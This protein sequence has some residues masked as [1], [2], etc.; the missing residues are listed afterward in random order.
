V[1]IV[2]TTILA[3]GWTAAAVAG[4]FAVELT[5]RRRV[6]AWAVVEGQRDLGQAFPA[7]E[8]GQPDGRQAF[9]RPPLGGSE[10]DR[11]Q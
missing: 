4:R 10:R 6:R 3:A 1:L 8:D 9:D 11:A 7:A 2:G 5:D